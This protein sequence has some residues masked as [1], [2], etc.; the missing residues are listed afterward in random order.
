MS[1]FPHLSRI[2]RGDTYLLRELLTYLG[3]R[4]LKMFITAASCVPI[5][6]PNE[7]YP[8]C[9]F[10]FAINTLYQ[11]L[12]F[13]LSCILCFPFI[14][15]FNCNFAERRKTNKYNSI[16]M[17]IIRINFNMKFFNMTVT[18]TRCFRT[19]GIF[20]FRVHHLRN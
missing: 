1:V 4:F 16:C 7:L 17:Y 2:K 10:M 9:L 19:P 20:F 14:V 12:L 8:V 15:Y 13:I 18:R 6:T 3:C 5:P 11:F